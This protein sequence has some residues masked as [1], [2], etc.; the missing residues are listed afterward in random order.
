MAIARLAHVALLCPKNETLIMLAKLIEFGEFH[1]L[2]REGLIQDTNVLIFSSRAQSIYASAS[3]FL[4]E[5]YSP[6]TAAAR[7]SP[8]IY[9]AKDIP[10]LLAILL[11]KLQQQEK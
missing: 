10:A 5:D 7:I 2:D 4:P 9:E 8:S 1:P 11:Q 3:H 6:T